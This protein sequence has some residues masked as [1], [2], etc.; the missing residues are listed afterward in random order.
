[1]ARRKNPDLTL[2]DVEKQVGGKGRKE[3]QAMFTA[4]T[5]QQRQK[6]QQQLLQQS[7]QR[8]LAAQ[9][10]SPGT[11]PAPP[12]AGTQGS[13]NLSAPP[14]RPKEAIF[15]DPS[16]A[17]RLQARPGAGAR[18]P[19]SSAGAAP[20]A[21]RKP[22]VLQS[23]RLAYAELP[24][25]VEDDETSVIQPMK[26]QRRAESTSGA[27]SDT[28]GPQVSEGPRPT[29]SLAASASSSP[30]LTRPAPPV[31]PSAPPVPVGPR[32]NL[33]PQGLSPLPPPPTPAPTLEPEAAS[34]RVA[35]ARELL[36]ERERTRSTGEARGAASSAAAP[37]AQ[38]AVE[39]REAEGTPPR[40]PVAP[41]L[42]QAPRA[43]VVPL[44]APPRPAPPRAPTLGAPAAGQ[45]A[46][47]VAGETEKGQQQLRSQ[48]I[49]V[50]GRP[51]DWSDG[52]Q[53]AMRRAV[54]R[55]RQEAALLD[56]LRGSDTVTSQGSLSETGLAEGEEG[57][58]DASVPGAEAP[59]MAGEGGGGTQTPVT[60]FVERGTAAQ[61]AQAGE[62]SSAPSRP[63]APP[64]QPP[65]RPS[66]PPAPA[67]PP[68]Q[69]PG[70]P[71]ADQ[72]AAY[73]PIP[74]LSVAPPASL[75]P[76]LSLRNSRPDSRGAPLLPPKPKEATAVPQLA[77]TERA[78]KG[79]PGPAKPRPF[80]PQP[81]SDPMLA[82][83]IAELQEMAK[84]GTAFEV[85]AVQVASGGI[86]VR[87]PSPAPRWR[88]RGTPPLPCSLV[89]CHGC[90]P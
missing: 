51:E 64:L 47:P 83:A 56:R 81:S 75:A 8:R 54:A 77:G 18:R 74:Q 60:N 70:A 59:D 24:P 45:Q 41:R 88:I 4:L 39:L 23:G 16:S 65:L 21:V 35:E 10:A 63:A 82:G 78:G 53:E 87:R 43:P 28:D 37:E 48:A 69:P 38:G 71:A 42:Q 26:V 86:R 9:G 12:A 58:E 6:Q 14:S 79:A 2:V 76:R 3:L 89:V 19:T 17:L 55:E 50:P 90:A 57:A 30:S 52:V 66:R 85:E 72:P 22:Q 62:A 80:V 29:A 34:T 49:P 61:L 73:P 13:P 11:P 84:N 40:E 67:V 20:V 46:K 31:P 32:P 68:L 15:Q 36:Q 1:M 44:A 7:Q 27:P 25:E 5:Q 33:A